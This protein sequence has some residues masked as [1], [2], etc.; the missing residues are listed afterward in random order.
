MNFVQALANSQQTFAS[1]VE[2]VLARR[3]LTVTGIGSRE[4]PA[5]VQAEMTIL[6]REFEQR[7]ARGRSGGAGGADLAFEAGYTDPRNCEIFHPWQRFIPKLDRRAVDVEAILGRKRPASGPGAAIVLEGEFFA[8]AEA[9]AQRFHPAWERCSDFARK[10]HTRNVPQ[11][12]GPQLDRPCDIIVCWTSDGEAS[13]GTGQAMRM[14]KAYDV[15]IVNL[16]R[17]EHRDAL[18]SALGL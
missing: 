13:G 14:A 5:D 8:R 7:G 10:M 12:L 17:R 4:T 18:F 9:I 3:D 16:K 11:V 2:A 6:A 15:L 1:K